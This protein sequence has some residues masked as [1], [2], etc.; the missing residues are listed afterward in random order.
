MNFYDEN[1]NLYILK[2]PQS[3]TKKDEI[4]KLRCVNIIFSKKD[5]I[6]VRFIKFNLNSTSM[7]VPSDFY[8]YQLFFSKNIQ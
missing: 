6:N 3:V 2:V 8:N 5:Q 4:I 1:N 7:K